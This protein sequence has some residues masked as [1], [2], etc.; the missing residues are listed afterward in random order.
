MT[1]AR[2]RVDAPASDAPASDAGVGGAG[3]GGGWRCAVRY[4][5]GA[6]LLGAGS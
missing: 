2:S 6:W 4:D 1:E 5:G 3:V